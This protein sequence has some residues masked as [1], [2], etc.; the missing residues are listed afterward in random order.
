[1]SA[2]DA[3]NAKYKAQNATCEKSGGDGRNAK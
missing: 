3:G 1:L 2:S